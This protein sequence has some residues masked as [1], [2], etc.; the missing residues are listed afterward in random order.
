MPRTTLCFLAL[1]VVCLPA[2]ADQ[3][4]TSTETVIRLTVHP[5][6]APKPALRYQLLP[7][8]RE[9][10]PGNPIQGY[11]L[12]FAE[13]Q[14]FF[15]SKEAC[16]RREKLQALPLTELS[17]QELQDYGQF[18]LRQADWAAR[19]DTPDWQILLKLKAEGVAV[20]I[21]DVQE[22]RALANA[23]KVRFRA[24]V[25]VHRFDDAL[26]TAKTIFAMS[27]HLGEHPT[28]I[29]NLVGV[30]VAYVAIGPLE[31]MLEQPG[32][33]NLYWALTYLPNH[34]VSLDKGAEGERLWIQPEFRDLD[35]SAPMS[36]DKLQRL[37]AH[38]DKLL[39]EEGKPKESK[40]RAWLDARNKDAAVVSAAC[41]RLVESGLPEERVLRFPADQVLLLDEKRECYVRQDDAVKIVNL[42]PWQVEALATHMRSNQRPALFD[43]APSIAK[44]RRAQGR[45]DQRLALLRHVEAL[46]LY[47]AEHRGKL[48]PKL[49]DISVPLPD[50]PFTGKPFRYEVTGGTAHLRGTPPPGTEKQPGWNIHYEVTIQK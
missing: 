9:M 36:A 46:R 26:R 27:R 40:V 14:K 19:L 37:V 6:A 24:A 12:C 34:L 5:M 30:A 20:S 39:F 1:A 15:F 45:L 32:C 2:R 50:D 21:P 41:R 18:A 10:N 31:E 8:L 25:A 11:L 44:I 13:Q 48:P 28:F 3:P 7:E 17:T 23:L 4:T 47:A 33:P 16:D 42:S 22:L 49:S 35:D 43:V 29:G 38:F